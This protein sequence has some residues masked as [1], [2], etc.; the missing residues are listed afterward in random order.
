MEIRKLTEKDLEAYR[1]LMRYAFETAK[2]NY[3]ELKW[4]SDKIPMD[5]HYGAFDEEALVAGA[6]IIPF[7]L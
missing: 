2:N 4:P 6:G 5:W 7:G 1:K 3:E